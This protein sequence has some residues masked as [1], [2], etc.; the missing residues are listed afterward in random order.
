MDSYEKADAIVS[1]IVDH[2]DMKE[3]LQIA[4]D[5]VYKNVMNM[6]QAEIDAQ[7]AAYFKDKEV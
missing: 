2:M 7:Y 6:G 3:L 4:Y 1:Y 5:V